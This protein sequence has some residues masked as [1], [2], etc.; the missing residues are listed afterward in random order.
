MYFL[1]NL[2]LIMHNYCIYF[3]LNFIF[4]KDDC[5]NMHEAQNVFICTCV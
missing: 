3:M 4:L 2:L 5:I 1:C